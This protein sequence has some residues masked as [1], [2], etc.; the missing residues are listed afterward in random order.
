MRLLPKFVAGLF[1]SV[2]ASVR[3]L[4][5][6][7]LA[8]EVKR[9]PMKEIEWS[10]LCLCAIWTVSSAGFVS[11]RKL[12]R[13]RCVMKTDGKTLVLG[14][15]LTPI[16]EKGLE[17]ALCST[18]KPSPRRR[19]QQTAPTL[20]FLPVRERSTVIEPPGSIG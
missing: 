6:E 11:S 2:A 4:F 1:G 19:L 13:K 8:A 3:R 5:E 17:N 16:P 15:G 12:M 7:Y 20:S 9:R 18:R 10:G 14:M